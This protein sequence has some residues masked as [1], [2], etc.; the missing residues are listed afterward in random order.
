MFGLFRTLPQGPFV[1][2][3]R[4]YS[5]TIGGKADKEKGDKIILPT[6]A[7]EK[8]ARMTV[9]YPMQFELRNESLEDI[10]RTHVGVLEFTAPEGQCYIPH[11]IMQNLLIMEGAMISVRNVT[12]P[13]AKFVKFRPRSVDFLDISNPKAVLEN[14]LRNFSC[15]TLDDQL[16]L[17]YNGKNYYVDVIELKPANAVSIVEADVEVDFAPPIG[18]V[19]P[20]RQQQQQPTSSS[21]SATTGNNKKPEVID[22][23][24]SSSNG[25]HVNGNSS[26]TTT[27]T[28]TATTKTDSNSAEAIAKERK[29]AEM[30]ELA[31]AREERKKQL[32]AK[33]NQYIAFSGQ[34][35]RVDGK[36][37]PS[38]SPAFGPVST[39]SVLL[40]NNNN[41]NSIKSTISSSSF[42]STSSNNSATL[43][44]TTSS[45]STNAMNTGKW[46]SRTQGASFLGEGHKLSGGE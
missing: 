13:L 22:L 37:S 20:Q 29:A 27:T 9:T 16:C 15:L 38:S 7:F 10:R 41:N 6:S 19:E 3:Y 14:T 25:H 24:G 30:A 11:W 26:A 45:S 39:A 23:T 46:K 35:R 1:E 40:N 31:K 4:C 33:N 34:G 5:V 2:I 12:L 42:Q 8:L 28:A 21:S 36:A 43:P 32:A 44:T 18:Y 17:P